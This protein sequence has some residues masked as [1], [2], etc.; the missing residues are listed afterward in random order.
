VVFFLS[1]SAIIIRMKIEIDQSGRVE[2]TSHDTVV[3]DSRGNG[4]WLTMKDK[5]LLQE[6]YR[7]SGRRKMFALEVFSALVAHV[8]A[9]GNNGAYD[10]FVI[11]KEYVGNESRIK[12][13]ILRYC[14]FLGVKLEPSQVD[15]G[16]VGKDSKAHVHAYRTFQSPQR[17]G[18]RL[19]SA[20]HL[21][22]VLTP[23]KKD[24]G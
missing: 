15:F 20:K 12:A 14:L 21:L 3:A 22:Q 1:L 7:M 11:D 8:I 9:D 18:C 24:R 23:Q 6:M 4:V 10:T 5:R 17:N 19:L 13:Y 2:Y 16:L